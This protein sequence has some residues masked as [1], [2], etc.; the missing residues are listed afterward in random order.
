[1]KKSFFI[2]IGFMLLL[3][4]FALTQYVLAISSSQDKYGEQTVVFDEAYP[5]LDNAYNDSEDLLKYQE[6]PNSY[7]SPFNDKVFFLKERNSIDQLFDEIII[8]DMV[9]KAEKSIDFIDVVYT[10]ILDMKWIDEERISLYAHS[11][12]ILDIYMIF[13]VNTGE[14]I[15]SYYGTDF[16]WDT[17]MEHVRYVLRQPYF[18]DLVGNDRIMYDGVPIYSSDN[19]NTILGGLAI[20]E[21]GILFFFEQSINQDCAFLVKALYNEEELWVNDVQKVAWDEPIGYIEISINSEMS[22][23][24]S[25]KEDEVRT[26]SISDIE[27]AFD[28]DTRDVFPLTVRDPFLENIGE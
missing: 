28:G 10:T 9:S 15:S 13:N 1:M 17:N 16:I 6:I 3:S 8:V 22:V 27:K 4:I 25:I 19:D 12:P 24:S 26:Y 5:A 18:S 23:R 20:S 11:N 7:I 2:I 21:E 14:V